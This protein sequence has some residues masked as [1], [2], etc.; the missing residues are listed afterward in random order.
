MPDKQPHTWQQISGFATELCNQ[1]D[2]GAAILAVA[3]LEDQLESVIYKRIVDIDSS[4]RRGLF[5][6][7]GFAGKIDTGLALGLYDEK[8][9]HTLQLIREVR[10]VFAHRMENVAFD[11][12]AIRQLIRNRATKVDPALAEVESNLKYVFMT[13][14][15]V[16]I[17][18]FYIEENRDIRIKPI[19]QTPNDPRELL[20]SLFGRKFS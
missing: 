1:T 11:D 2:R 6:R 17:F 20:A 10:N 13:L 15:V 5:G 3:I 7:M 14:F 18:I 19:D 12:P 16:A 4:I 9:Y 8:T